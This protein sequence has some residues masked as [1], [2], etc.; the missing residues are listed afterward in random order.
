MVSVACVHVI[1]WDVH[2][3]LGNACGTAQGIDQYM[4]A[5]VKKAAEDHSVSTSLLNE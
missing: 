3:A 2:E 1:W 5:R 4:E